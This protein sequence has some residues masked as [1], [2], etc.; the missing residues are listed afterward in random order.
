MMLGLVFKPGNL[1]F[2]ACPVYKIVLVK[3]LYHLH[4]FTVVMS[5]IFFYSSVLY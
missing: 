1:E 3:S 2:F 5:C 4:H